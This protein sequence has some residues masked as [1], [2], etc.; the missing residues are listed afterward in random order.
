MSQDFNLCYPMN[1]RPTLNGMVVEKNAAW[2]NVKSQS[3][4][5]N[6]ENIIW[7]EQVCFSFYYSSLDQRESPKTQRASHNWRDSEPASLEWR[8]IRQVRNTEASPTP[9]RNPRQGI[10]TNSGDFQ[11]LETRGKLGYL[12]YPFV[13]I[14]KIN[15]S[16]WHL[17]HLLEPVVLVFL[18]I[19]YE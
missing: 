13:F 16:R 12:S 6:R 14:V 2:K 19:W 18:Y 7:R 4:S 8:K 11:G 15:R 5:E 1:T 17:G 9:W 3:E 10:G